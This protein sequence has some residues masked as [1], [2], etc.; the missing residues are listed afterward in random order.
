MAQNIEHIAGHLEAD[1]DDD[2]LRAICDHL[3]N[4]AAGD[5]DADRA[6]L[7]AA[8]TET[9]T[10]TVGSRP[11][12]GCSAGLVDVDGHVLVVFSDD[13]PAGVI[14]VCELLAPW[15]AGRVEISCDDGLT[16]TVI[17][18]GRVTVDV[19]PHLVARR[20]ELWLGQFIFQDGDVYVHICR[21]RDEAYKALARHQNVEIPD[22]QTAEEVINDLYGDCEPVIYVAPVN[23]FQL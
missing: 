5:P 18:D 17:R 4:S 10:D 22:G 11:W 8:L 7:V 23:T 16:C 19:K 15:F 12:G 13:A 6:V 2:A 3:G 9:I 20:D 21:S 14:E 1:L